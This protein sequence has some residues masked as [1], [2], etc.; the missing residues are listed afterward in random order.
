MSAIPFPRA[1]GPDDDGEAIVR[2]EDLG[3]TIEEVRQRWPDAVEHG[4]ASD[5]YWLVSDLDIPESGDE[6][7]GVE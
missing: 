6:Q 2:A 5:P 4:T 3:M 1:S 7:G